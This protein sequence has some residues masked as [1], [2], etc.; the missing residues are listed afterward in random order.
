M[1]IKLS[2]SDWKLVGEQTGWMKTA[3]YNPHTREKVIEPAN[4]NA[5]DKKLV[6][7][8]AKKAIEKLGFEAEIISSTEDTITIKW[9]NPLS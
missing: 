9:S 2:K 5:V 6:Q 7:D 4:I 1:K 8:I 3:Q